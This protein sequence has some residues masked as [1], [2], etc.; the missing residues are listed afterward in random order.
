M[1]KKVKIYPWVG[2]Q[3]KQSEVLPFKTLI[4]GE[5]NY[6]A[7][8]NFNSNIVISCVTNHLGENKNKNFSSFAT[9]TRRVILGSSTKVSSK[10]FW[11]SV[12]YYNFVQYLVGS[13]SRKRPT[14][15]MWN[16]SV[17]SFDE[18]I[19]VLKPERVLVLG[20]GNW[21]NLLKHFN[22]KKNGEYMATFDINGYSFTAGYINHPSSGISYAEW[23]PIANK[24]L[25]KTNN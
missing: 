3:Y 18:L 7:E 12:A 14:K 5:S 22:H 13:I 4:L 25:I 1:W 15:Q 17:Q 23:Q 16:E 24:I 8:K 21:K 20:K 19:T 2:S 9:K 10:I 11:E 6:A